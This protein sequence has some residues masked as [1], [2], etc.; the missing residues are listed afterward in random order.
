MYF[1]FYNITRYI[2]CS[3]QNRLSE[4]ILISTNNIPFSM[5]KMKIALNHPK[6]AA[7]G[8]FEGIGLK[9]EFETAVAN[10]PSIFEPLNVYC[11][12]KS[13]NRKLH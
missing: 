4:A 1:R 12:I 11:T 2:V 13:H 5:Q 8:F 7:M 3:H 9:K 6:S 10:A